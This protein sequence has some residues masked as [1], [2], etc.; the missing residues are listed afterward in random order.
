MKTFTEMWDELSEYLTCERGLDEGYADGQ[1]TKVFAKYCKQVDGIDISENFYAI[2]KENLKNYSNV[3]LHV[4]DAK[5]T[6]FPDKHFDVILNTSFHEFDLS[7]FGEFKINLPLKAKM[8]EEMVRL[9]D[10]IV[11]AEVAPENI[12]RELHKVFNPTE[13]HSIRITKSN[14]LILEDRAI[15]RIYFNNCEEFTEEMLAWYADI[16]VPKDKNEKK[17]MTNQIVDILK[18]ENMLGNLCLDNVFRYA[19]Y[20]KRTN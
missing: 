10:T 18:K 7:G 1:Y 14:E 8:L 11:F 3:V 6:N 20:K 15:D 19:V 2:A 9:S 12:E 5:K 4:M 17:Q 16:R 13:E